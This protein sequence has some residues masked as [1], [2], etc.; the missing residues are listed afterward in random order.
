MRIEH[1]GNSILHKISRSCI[2]GWRDARELFSWIQRDINVII[3]DIEVAVL[4]DA[5]R[6]FYGKTSAKNFLVE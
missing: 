5:Y 6:V 1:N 4:F 3:P 2:S